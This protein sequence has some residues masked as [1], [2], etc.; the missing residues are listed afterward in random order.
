MIGETETGK[1]R[2]VLDSASSMLVGRTVLVWEAFASVCLLQCCSLRCSSLG[3]S[4]N[5]MDLNIDFLRLKVIYFFVF[6]SL[7]H[8]FAQLNVI[9]SGI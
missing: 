7:Q 2:Y 6:Y 1:G 3:S 8:R 5:K 9:C 4:S